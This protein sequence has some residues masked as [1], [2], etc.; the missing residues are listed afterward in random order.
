MMRSDIHTAIQIEPVGR[1]SLHA[2]IQREVLATLFPGMLDEPIEKRGAESAGAI[3]IVR[4]EIVDIE[5]AAGKKE[6][7]NAK[8]RDGMDATVL[9]K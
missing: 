7:E 2:G 3:R 1:K 9:F 6:T 5:S 4:D 8:A